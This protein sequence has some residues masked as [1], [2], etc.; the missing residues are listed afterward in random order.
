MPVQGLRRV[1]WTSS[2]HRN[3]S[4]SEAPATASCATPRSNRATLSAVVQLS[5]AREMIAA[6]L[7]GWLIPGLGRLFFRLFRVLCGSDRGANRRG[8]R[9]GSRFLPGPLPLAPSI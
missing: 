5:C 6:W 4:P 2:S 9:V 3:R 1:S 7:S 8:L